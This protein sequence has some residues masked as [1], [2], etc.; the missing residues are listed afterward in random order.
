MTG[1]PTSVQVVDPHGVPS[2]VRNPAKPVRNSKLQQ[3]QRW[4][5]KINLGLS[6][7]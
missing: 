2:F 1:R 3:K 4:I 6:E 5:E 7:A